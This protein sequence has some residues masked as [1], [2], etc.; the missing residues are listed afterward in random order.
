MAGVVDAGMVGETLE[1]FL[2]VMAEVRRGWLLVP[3]I[4]EINQS[5]YL[6][7][8]FKR[9]NGDC[10]CTS[11]LYGDESECIQ[12]QYDMKDIMGGYGIYVSAKNPVGGA[13]WRRGGMADTVLWK[14]RRK[15]RILYGKNLEKTGFLPEKKRKKTLYFCYGYIT[16]WLV[17]V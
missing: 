16:M 5:N 14:K 1:T 3:V 4:Q 6:L 17:V 7:L 9:T 15:E 11:L 12:A 10:F 8:Q 13:W 2:G